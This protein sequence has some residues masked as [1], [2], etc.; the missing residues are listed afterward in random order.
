[1]RTTPQTVA[2]ARALLAWVKDDCEDMALPDENVAYL[3]DSL[4]ASPVL[5]VEV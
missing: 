1:V 4:L 5:A 2:G 3:V